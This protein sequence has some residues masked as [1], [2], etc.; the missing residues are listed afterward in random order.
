MDVRDI[1][2]HGAYI[3]APNGFYPAT[4]MNLMLEN[5]AIAGSS[6]SICVQV[7]RQTEDGFCV[8]FLPRDPRER[9]KLARFLAGVRQR[10]AADL[11]EA[12]PLAPSE[13]PVVIEPLPPVDAISV[14]DDPIGASALPEGAGRPSELFEELVEATEMEN[15]RRLSR[16]RR[17]NRGPSRSADGQALIEFALLLPL[18]FLLIVNVINF[19]GLLYAWITVSNSARVGAQYY[20]TGPATVGAPARPSESAVQSL[21]INDLKA[22]PNALASQVCVSTSLSSTVSCN[23]GS[24]PFT[25]PPP[26]ETA[27]GTPPITFAVAAVD[28]TYTYQPFIPLWDFTALQV[29][30]TLPP[31]AIHR[32]AIMRI[33]Q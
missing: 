5:Q 11:P 8:S 3:R 22:L 7:G 19:G 14:G 6:L 15:R 26:A 33:L 24:A 17:L 2:L 29:H 13:E 31:T 20:I 25:A 18:L 12:P 4:L 32:Q 1:G 16:R 27:E 30:A 28:V 10:S 9:R 21:V 23:S